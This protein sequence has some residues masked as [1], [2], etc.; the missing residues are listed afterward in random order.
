MSERKQK[1]KGAAV[2]FI[3]STLVIGTV[4]GAGIWLLNVEVPIRY[5]QPYIISMSDEERLPEWETLR[6]KDTIVTQEADFSYSGLGTQYHQYV[7]IEN[8]EGGANVNIMIDITEPASFD[9][10]MGFTILPGIVEPGEADNESVEEWGSISHNEILAADQTVEFTAIYTLSTGVP[11]DDGTHSITWEFRE[12]EVPEGT[13]LN[14]DTEET[15]IS[16]NDA[17]TNAE[18]GHTILVG[19]GTYNE[20]NV[21][22]FPHDDITLTGT[23]SNEVFIVR[24]GDGNGVLVS[25]R[26]GITINGFTLQNAG[27]YGFKLQSWTDDLLIEDVVVEDS[28]R[29]GFD[30]NKVTNVVLDRVV[31]LNNGGN[32][33]SILES[34]GITISD[35]KTSGNAWGGIAMYDDI[36]DITVEGSYFTNE[37]AAIYF[38]YE[39]HN[40][41][42]IVNNEFEDLVLHEDIEYDGEEYSGYVYLAAPHLDIDFQEVIDNNIFDHDVILVI[43]EDVDDPDYDEAQAIVHFIDL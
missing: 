21:L 20:D 10:D 1:F 3:A 25:G 39:N 29:T 23:G 37:N 36:D 22:S 26:S 38:Q 19:P 42:V 7:S 24:S 4:L 16:I 31:S 41:I 33:I 40:N 5:D 11:E 9:D 6:F 35:A 27:H 8:P 43:D 14:V 2:W 34:T 13:V 17:L 12:G 28:T 18:A 15:Y 30:L 32:G